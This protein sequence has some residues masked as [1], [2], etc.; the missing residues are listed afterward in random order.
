MRKLIFCVLALSLAACGG[1]NSDRQAASVQ[2]ESEVKNV[3]FLIGD[4]MGLSHLSAAMLANATPLAIQRA[5]YVGL[6]TTGSASSEVTDSAAAG[7]ALATGTKT[8]NGALGVDTLNRPLISI[9][10]RA[11]NSGRATGVIATHSVTDATPA[12]FVAN[13]EDRGNE[14]A[15]AEDF[16]KTDIDLFIGG[17]RQVFEQRRDGRNI[18]EEMRAK[19]YHMFHSLDSLRNIEQGN[20]GVLLADNKLPRMLQ[21]RGD[22]LPQATSEA[23]RILSKNSPKGFFVMIEGSQ[24]DGGGHDNDAEAVISEL[25]DFDQ[26][27]RVAMDFADSHPGTLVVV[28]ADHETGG[29]SLPSDKDVILYGKTQPGDGN[30]ATTAFSTKGH[31]ASMIPIYAYGAG[32][33]RFTG[34]MDNTDI[35]KRMAELMGLE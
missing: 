35:P 2:P 14:E 5:Q 8:R 12:A 18:T 22:V 25:V 15:I 27:V 4:G 30:H 7:T 17:G 19:G 32:A 28:T 13:N 26:A 16:L 23:L 29:M 10:K 31:T 21:G 3:I 20:V 34:I 1:T 9:L 11:E 24:I 33:E 6:Q